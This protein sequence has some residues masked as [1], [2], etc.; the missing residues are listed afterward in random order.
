MPHLIRP[1]RVDSAD[2]SRL[3]IRPHCYQEH[4]ITRY[5]RHKRESL[6]HTLSVN[7]ACPQ[8]PTTARGRALD[9]CPRLP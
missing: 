6:D 7:G 9:I 1:S 2:A 8:F 3:A 5:S 4:Y